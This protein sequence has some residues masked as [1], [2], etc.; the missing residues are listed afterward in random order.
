MDK[1]ICFPSENKGIFFLFQAN[2]FS[3]LFEP[4]DC[5]APV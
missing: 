5:M 4:K 1:K 3:L 2:G